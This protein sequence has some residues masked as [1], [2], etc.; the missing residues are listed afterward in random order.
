MRE[1]RDGDLSKSCSRC[2]LPP[3]AFGFPSRI[4]D[5]ISMAFENVACFRTQYK[6]P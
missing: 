5:P 2:G 1:A 6:S 3:G 4:E